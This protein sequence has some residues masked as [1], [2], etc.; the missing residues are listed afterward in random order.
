MAKTRLRGAL[1]C[2]TMSLEIAVS[3]SPG[4]HSKKNELST[5]AAAN[6]RSIN[7]KPTAQS[8]LGNGNTQT[9]SATFTRSDGTLR[10][11]NNATGCAAHR[12]G[13]HFHAANHSR[14]GHGQWFYPDLYGARPVDRDFLNGAT[15]P[16]KPWP[17]SANCCAISAPPWRRAGWDVCNL[18]RT[19][20]T[21]V[22]CK[23][24]TIRRLA[25][26]GRHVQTTGLSID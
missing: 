4:R 6:I 20:V 14:P 25:A 5:L 10:Q 18:L 17:T 8:D 24:A 7:L 9:A 16:L 11:T 19:G 23:S 2:T 3:I 21:S 12:L 26:R 15:T 1:I 13:R 22:Q